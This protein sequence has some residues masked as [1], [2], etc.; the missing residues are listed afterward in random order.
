M[1]YPKVVPLVTATA[2]AMSAFI[3]RAS[4]RDVSRKDDEDE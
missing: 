3:D 4:D 2:H 1:D